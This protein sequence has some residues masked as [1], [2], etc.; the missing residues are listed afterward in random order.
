M[1]GLADIWWNAMSGFVLAAMAAVR[2]D[3]S[4]L[5]LMAIVGIVCLIVGVA[6][7]FAWRVKRAL[8]AILLVAAAILTPVA[9]TL[10]NV[11]IGPLGV[12]FAVLAGGLFLIVGTAVFAHAADRR[13][14]VWLIGAFSMCL[15][16]YCAT[17]GG[18]FQDLS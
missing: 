3:L 14:P 5:P 11:L 13:V 2:G 6:L 17:V 15:A 1:N 8:R 10:A 4:A 18:A 12:L 16:A 7:L 9:T